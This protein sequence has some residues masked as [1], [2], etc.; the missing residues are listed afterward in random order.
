VCI[1]AYCDFGY[2]VLK[3]KLSLLL[4]MMEGFVGLV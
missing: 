2:V 4:T 1:W 3:L